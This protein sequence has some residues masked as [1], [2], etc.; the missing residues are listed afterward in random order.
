MGNG[1]NDFKN[2]GGW[3]DR[4]GIKK[5]VFVENHDDPCLDIGEISPRMIMISHIPPYIAWRY[6][7]KDEFDLILEIDKGE[8]NEKTGHEVDAKHLL[9]F[10]YYDI[11]PQR[12]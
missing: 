5:L 10:R 2:P 9:Y 11:I 4:M 3:N 7:H 12:H 6:L 1:L 8:Q